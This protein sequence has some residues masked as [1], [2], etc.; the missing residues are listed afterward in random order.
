MPLPTDDEQASADEPRTT[1]V[2]V[3][4][5]YDLLGTVGPHRRG[6]GDPQMRIDGSSVWRAFRTP[7]GPATL[8]LDPRPAAGEVT[9]T[10]WGPGASWAV[11]QAPQLLGLADRP[12]EWTPAHPV[13]RQ[14][15]RAGAPLRVGRTGLVLESLVPSV[16]EQKVTGKEAWRSWR[17]LLWRHGE[18][19]PGP[20]PLRI[21]PTP[22]RL[23]LL[24]S[25]DWHRAGV[26]AKRSLT[27]RS[28]ALR[29]GRVEECVA[30][31]TSDARRR[32]EA[33]PGVGLWTSA[34]VAQR[35]LGDADAVSVGD[36]HLPTLV[37][38]ALTGTATDDD[39]MLA[40]LE[41]ER[42][43]R[44]RAV[45]LLEL[46][47]RRPERRGPRMSPRQFRGM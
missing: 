37:G 4:A 3:A 43:H 29:A 14:L 36:Y 44:Y 28:A 18:V 47:G 42:P 34:E 41:A 24:A 32:L 30:M 46:F 21:L 40:L 25:W 19:A 10:A 20:V 26:E 1:T 5:P 45:R 31:A 15:H 8:R 7:I 38:F 16:L 17:E 13:L 23:A 2:R 22:A 6:S 9:A 12:D 11:E 27:I 35:A 39:G 33:L